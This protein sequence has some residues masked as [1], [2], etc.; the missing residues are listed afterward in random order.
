MKKVLGLDIGVNSVGYALIGSDTEDNSLKILKTGVRIVNE[1]PDF[2][3][4]FYQGNSASKNEARR[5]KRMIRRGNQRFKAR[6]DALYRTLRKNSMFPSDKL[7]NRVSEGTLYRLRAMAVSERLTLEEI[8]RVFIHLNQRRGYKSN[9]KSEKKTEEGSYLANIAE[10]G[11]LTKDLTIGQFWDAYISFKS[12][13]IDRI[14]IVLLDWFRFRTETE[15][16]FRIRETIFPR[17]SYISEFDKIWECQA[18]F[19]PTVLTGMPGKT[20]REN[21]GT[22]YQRIRN[23]IIFYQRKLKSQKHLVSDCSFE[24][25]HKVV[26][27]SSP[28]YQEFRIWQQINNLEVTDLSNNKMPIESEGRKRVFDALHDTDQLNKRNT[29]PYTAILK[30]LGYSGRSYHL[31]FNMLEGNKT[32]I[33]IFNALK[34]AGI[35]QPDRYLSFDNTQKIV[36]KGL[37]DLWHITY[38]LDDESDVIKTLVKRYGFTYNQA[39]I[40][41]GEL[42]YTSDYGSLSTRAIRKLLP[43]L[44]E[45][46]NYYEACVTVG[47]QNPEHVQREELKIHMDNIFPNSLRNPV[48]EQVLNQVVNVVNGIIDTYGHID[49]VRVEL[50]RDLKNN[51]KQR[52]ELTK[53]NRNLRKLNDTISLRLKQEHGFSR[54]SG[55]DLLRYR[56]WDETEKRCLYCGQNITVSQLYNGEAE[57]EHI[58]PWSR[59]FNDAMTNKI[60]AHSKCNRDK[61]QMTAY[62]FMAS[63]GEAELGRYVADVN[64]LF[65]EGSGRLDSDKKVRITRAKKDNLLCKG[66]EIKGDFLA[67]QLKD[68]QYI[69]LETVSRLKD[70]FPKVTTTT[71]S[72]T[73]YLKETWQLKSLIDEMNIDKY[74][75]VGET[76]WREEKD[77]ENGLKKVER[78]KNW[79]KRDDHRHHALDA[80]VVALTTQGII[81][82]INNA[83]KMFET[84]REMKEKTFGFLPPAPD[85]RRKAMESLGEILVSFK[86]PG[87]KVLSRKVNVINT[88]K[89]KKEQVTWAPRGSLHEDTIF[90]ICRWYEKIKVN[91][92][93]NEKTASQ[94]VGEEVRMAVLERLATFNGDSSKAFEKSLFLG[95]KEIKEVTILST[96]FTKRVTLSEKIT[97]AQVEKIID[98]TIQKLVRERIESKGGIKQAFR[99]YLNDPIWQN[100]EKGIMLKHVTVFDDGNLESV[101]NGYVYT[102]GNHHALIYS[103]ANGRYFDHIVS[104]WEA[105]SNCLVNLDTNGSIYPVIDRRDKGNHKF[106]FSMQINDLFVFDVNP[107]EVNFFDPVNKPLLAKNLY[108]VQAMSKGDYLFRHQY[109]ATVQK[110]YDFTYKRITSMD[111]LKGAVKIRINHLGDIIK[112]GE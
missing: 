73:D 77:R 79:S 69:V 108:R 43:Y 104:F 57:I 48:V 25:G 98:P 63:K 72:V 65:T 87:S 51:A 112:I 95:E 20:F 80:L 100:T 12:N 74:R 58:I 99:D 42:G 71:G 44:E 4:N 92:K 33:T 47:Y 62:D 107:E 97:P 60:I 15:P 6:R 66:S 16:D 37:Y 85:L 110:K 93:L 106:V 36:S 24:K 39:E 38:S 109:E 19:Y 11:E 75:S 45:G 76:E 83:N 8:G 61:D 1:D 40:I 2:H 9:R 27:K 68:T 18:S 10:L 31:N 67:R 23:E 70:V 26:P 46:K 52:K 59:S 49:E 21:K 105:V 82:R 50:A 34:K 89:G 17:D 84:T 29:L 35:E 54:V 55:S 102:K 56:L 86:K 22:L 7:L 3:G 90:G 32:Y 41:A 81:Q 13:N 111:K 28:F 14:P 91:K 101:R 78:I 5:T 53:K 88:S 64:R 30:I 96:R 103:D 94:I